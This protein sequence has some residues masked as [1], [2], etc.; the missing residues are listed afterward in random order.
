MSKF[1]IITRDNCDW[2]VKAKDLLT[3]KGYKYAER[4]VADPLFGNEYKKK[5]KDNGLTTVPQVWHN[6]VYVGGYTQLKE[7]LEL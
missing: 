7:Y 1:I 3:K 2:C 6:D 5:L 4:N